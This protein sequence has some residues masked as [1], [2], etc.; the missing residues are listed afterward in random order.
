MY[1]ILLS[2][3]FGLQ[4]IF[5]EDADFSGISNDPELLLDPL[6]VSDMIQNV[7]F[8][9]SCEESSVETLQIFSGKC[10]NFQ[11]GKIYD[12][13]QFAAVCHAL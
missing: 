10:N 1:R 2:S 4:Q 12:F 6:R 3:Q 9:V 11:Y 7:I 8:D 13:L 5:T